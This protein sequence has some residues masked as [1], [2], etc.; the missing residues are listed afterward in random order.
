M[1]KEQKEKKR[2]E[3]RYPRWLVLLLVFII[4]A[5]SSAT[6]LTLYLSSFLKDLP[7]VTILRN[8]KPS[9]T[10]YVYDINHKP[11]TA[12]FQE[13][14]I[15][16]NIED[17]P[18]IVRKAVIAIEDKRFYE[19]HGIDLY[20]IFG[21]LIA[22]IRHKKAVQGGSTITQQLAKNVFL[23]SQ[24][25][26]R[27]KIREALLAMKIEHMYTKQQILEMYLN[28]I[29]LGSGVYGIATAA[30]YF[31]GKDVS[32]LDLAEASMLAG[33]IRA[34]EYYSP[35]YHPKRA[36]RRQKLV[37]DEMVKAGYIT[38]EM[39]KKAYEEPLKL[40]SPKLARE[41]KAPYFVS[42]ILKKLIK[43][44]GATKVF[45]GGWKIYTTLNLKYQK[46]AQEAMAKSKFQGAI[47]SINPN[48]GYIVAMVGG[49]DFSKSQFNRATQAFRQP[50]SAFKPFIYTTAIMKG[51][52]ESSLIEDEP[53]KFPNG[54]EPHN[55]TKKYHG[56]VTLRAALA[57]S[58]NVA[59]VRLLD[60]IGIKDVIK[61]A[62]EMGITSKLNEDL[63][64]ALGTSGVTPLEMASAYGTFATEGIHYKPLAILKIVDSNG[65]IVE[66][67]HPEGKRVLSKKV[68]YIMI[69]MLRHVVRE[70]TGRRAYFGVPIAGKTGT[71][72]NYTDAWFVGFTP[73]LVTA[74][75]IGKDDHKSLGEHMAGGVVAA[76]I[77]KTFMEK[78]VGKNSPDF[79]VPEGI[80]LVSVCSISGMLPTPYCP[81]TTVEA[82]ISGT[83]P[84]E[85]CTIHGKFEETAPPQTKKVITP[86]KKEA[87]KKKKSPL[88]KKKKLTKKEMKEI[89]KKFEELLKKYHIKH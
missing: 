89:Q 52:T 57:H 18:P 15:W 1:K 68:A 53:I 79:D 28:T 12:L 14:R 83:E 49:K 55:Y 8:Y 54:W 27:R 43:K 69:D 84:T 50:G 23:S 31:F 4:V 22:D 76:P 58:Y 85:Y 88:P 82:F 81:S 16:K 3:K 46:Y 39:A 63:S 13:N 20:R 2:K 67:N 70:G 38:K 6:A 32:Q 64:L 66:E 34:P 30:K 71:T 60:Q 74:V 36:K 24:K 5:F 17:I 42:Y 40:L 25:T 77:W 11:I 19:H 33:L 87:K 41:N 37:L 21:A 29:Y 44:Y 48:N 78:A 7:N 62:H 26:V 61:V 65:N 86:Q 59:T 47:V 73:N 72:D 51:Y 35:Y 56:L 10:T 75:Y 80:K 9:L 45:R